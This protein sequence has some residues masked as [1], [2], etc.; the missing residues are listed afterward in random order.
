MGIL[1]P[2]LLIGFTCEGFFIV[3][4]HSGQLS[5]REFHLLHQWEVFLQ[6]EDI[7]TVQQIAGYA[8]LGTTVTRGKGEKTGCESSGISTS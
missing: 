6:V 7:A 8:S 5:H 2:M 1:K 4:L 3:Y